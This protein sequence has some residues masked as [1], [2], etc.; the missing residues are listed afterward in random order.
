MRIFVTPWTVAARPICTCNSS[1]QNS[2]VCSCSLL[3]GIFPT[4]GI[5]SGLLH[6]KQ[7]LYLLSHQG[8]KYKRTEAKAVFRGKND[9]SEPSSGQ[10]GSQEPDVKVFFFS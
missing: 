3:Q 5:N 4:P 10:R 6:C 9:A 7:I 1:G 8:S 2:G